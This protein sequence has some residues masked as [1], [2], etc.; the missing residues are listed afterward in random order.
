[1]LAAAAGAGGLSGGIYMAARGLGEKLFGG[2]CTAAREHG[3]KLGGMDMR[4]KHV[5][6]HSIPI[7]FAPPQRGENVPL[8]ESF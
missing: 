5:Q 3:E 2:M 6:L 7:R 4:A 1:M 8:R